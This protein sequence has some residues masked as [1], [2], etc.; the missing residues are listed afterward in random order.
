MPPAPPPPPPAPAPAAAA[1][2]PPPVTKDRSALLNSIQKGTKLKKAQTNDRSAPIVGGGGV[3]GD[4]SKA[5]GRSTKPSGAPPVPMPTSGSAGTNEPPIPASAPKLGGLFSQGMPKLRKVGNASSAASPPQPSKSSTPVSSPPPPP[6]S[7]APP[8]P[9]S[10]P[11]IPSAPAPR[12]PT[13][14]PQK[15]SRSP[16]PTKVP[17]SPPPPI[18]SAPSKAPP[19]PPQ[20]APPLGSHIPMSSRVSS[21]NSQTLPPPPPPPSH[22]PSS[23]IPASSYTLQHRSDKVDDHGRF[24]FKDD[25]YLP[26]PRRF[27]G[28]PKIYRG[29]TGSTVPLRLD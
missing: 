19:L 27:R 15:I 26:Q 14:L 9:P 6:V 3:V 24:Q 20:S 23:P 5:G 1:P 11:S 2:A 13:S 22:P 7:S 17:S 29:S 18:P 12:V 28:G 4:A 21:G 8:I 25:S 10:A 16:S